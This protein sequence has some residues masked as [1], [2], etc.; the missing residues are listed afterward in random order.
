M[1]TSHPTPLQLEMWHAGECAAALAPHLDACERCQRVLAGL[2][3]ERR[4]LIARLPPAEF[5][6][7]VQRRMAQPASPPRLGAGWKGSPGVHLAAAGCVM[8]IALIV[9]KPW[10]TPSIEP[11][12]AAMNEFSPGSVK[13]ARATAADDLV[14]KGFGELALIVQRQ[15]QQRLMTG[16]VTLLPGD[17]VRV[18]FRADRRARWRAGI[19]LDTGQ[20]V[21]LFEGEFGVGTHT[22]EAT[23]EVDEQPASGHLVLGAP[24]RVAAF[25]QNGDANGVRLI[26]IRSPPGERAETREAIPE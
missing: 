19:L 14:A 6:Q 21:P 1:P 12:V 22:P 2:E 11:Q 9:A 4:S 17:Q 7:I 24:D 3:D 8:L 16:A 20:W 26:E 18:R 15:G 5:L 13:E 10:K 25:C 23:L